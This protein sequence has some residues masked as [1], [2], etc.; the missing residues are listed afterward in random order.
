MF[1]RDTEYY[2]LLMQ[3][4]VYEQQNTTVSTKMTNL[5]KMADGNVAYST[6][7]VESK[8]TDNNGGK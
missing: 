8:S 4:L 5:A 3:E 6:G 2:R 1:Q 7:F